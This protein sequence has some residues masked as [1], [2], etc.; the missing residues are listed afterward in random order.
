MKVIIIED[1]HSAANR[2]RQMLLSSDPEIQIVAHLDS[3]KASVQWLMDHPSPD[4]V[5]LDIHLGDGLSFEIFELVSIDVP[6]IFITAYN[7]YALQA[8]RLHS[9]DYLLKPLER[10]ALHKS[11][12]KY[13]KYFS[14]SRNSEVPDIKE[15]LKD[16]AFHSGA[17]YKNRFLIKVGEHLR[18]VPVE[19][20][21]FIVSR[22]GGNFLQCNDKKRWLMD[23][24]MEEIEKQLNPLR[25]FRINRQ[26]IVA[27]EAIQ[28]IVAYSNS[29]LKL[30]L[31]HGLEDK[32]VVVSRDKVSD[33]K[34][35][36]DR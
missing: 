27:M 25:F 30:V 24:T 5:F 7:D 10:D 14:L 21:L 35:W 3:V 20:I 28:D 34:R 17:Q 4:L 16:I 36:L 18:S 31:K 23:L 6:V 9:V 33:F 26:Y 12:D 2:L 15:I 11:L 22:E 19:E 1:E 13:K 8:F 29:R 32:D